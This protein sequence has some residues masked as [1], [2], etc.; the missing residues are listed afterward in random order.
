MN[1][2]TALPIA[3]NAALTP[4]S[5]MRACRRRAGL[6]VAACAKQIA[7]NPADQQTARSDLHRL[8]RDV[9]GD[10]GRLVTSLRDRGVFA[11]DF[12]MFSSLAAETCDA[13]LDDVGSEI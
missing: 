3:F 4:G 9:P 11:F 12:V 5:Y 8:E 6:T 2:M 7:V 13:S 10:Y 1:A